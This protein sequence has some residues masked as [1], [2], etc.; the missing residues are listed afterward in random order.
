GKGDR[1]VGNMFVPIDLLPPILGDLIADGRVAGPG[2]PWIGINTED[3]RGHMMISRVT[4]EGPAER[5]G[6][7]RHDII[8]GI[9]GGEAPKSV[10]DLYRKIWAQGN[11]GA[12]ISLDVQRE[13]ARIHIDVK[14]I[15]RLDH[16]KLKSTF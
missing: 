7:R 16:L 6:L 5:A 8:L 2:R 1:T 14:S 4:P 12:T 11:A 3:V 13:T 15:N 10:A 9:N